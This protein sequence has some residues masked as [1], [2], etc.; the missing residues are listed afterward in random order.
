M[1]NEKY[2][3]FFTGM[4]YFGA[5][6]AERLIAHFGSIKEVFCATDS[7]LMLSGLLCPSELEWIVTARRGYN[8][9]AEYEKTIKSGIRYVS[10]E[11][12]LYP[13]RLRQIP[14]YP[15]GLFYR[16]ELPD[17]ARPAVAVIGSRACTGYGREIA[18]S[19]SEELA[20]LGIDI[21]SGMAAGIDGH[22]HRGALAGGGRTFAILGN[23][24]DICYPPANKD[25]YAEIPEHGGLISEYPPGRQSLP[26]N[27]PQRNRIISGLADGILVVEARQR[28]GTGITVEMGL[29][30]GKDIY[31]IPGRIGDKLSD[32]CNKLIRQ[33]A[34]LV[35]SPEDIVAEMAH[36][37]GYLVDR[38]GTQGS[39]GRK[40]KVK[41]LTSDQAMVLKLLDLQP[42][43]TSEL[44]FRTGLDFAQLMAALTFLELRGLARSTGDGRFTAGSPN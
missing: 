17:S 6:A 44:S 8:A 16:G 7:E 23:G 28:S 12:R 19:F 22:S 18:V 20:R 31:A 3:M 25:I 33:G 39:S 40:K 30:Q 13:E 37:Y 11:N 1:E 26:G 24:V 35:T 41:G 14:D 36:S 29:E 34:R 27:F 21:I 15:L 43:T 38:E 32:G 5:G 10:C 42:K 2:W 9:D 4:D